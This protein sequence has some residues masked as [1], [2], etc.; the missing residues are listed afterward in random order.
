MGN[1]EISEEVAA[2]ED[3][4][5][6]LQRE[7]IFLNAD[8]SSMLRQR[9]NELRAAWEKVLPRRVSSWGRAGWYDEDTRFRLIQASNPDANCTMRPA[10]YKEAYAYEQL[11]FIGFEE[12]MSQTLTYNDPH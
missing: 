11:E 1:I 4:F 6:L 8:L 10:G 3:I 5:T 7:G 9:R 2:A 12:M